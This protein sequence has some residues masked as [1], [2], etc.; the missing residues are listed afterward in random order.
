MVPV[1]A[2]LEILAIATAILGTAPLFPYL[3]IIPQVA[4]PAALALAII[5]EKMG[6]PNL[7][8]W[9]ATTLTG[10]FFLYYSLQISRDNVVDPS[11]NLLVI[12]LSIRLAGEKSPRNYLQIYALSIFALAASSLFSLSGSFLLYLLLILLSIAISLVLLTFFTIDNRLSLTRHG[13]WRVSSVAAFMPIASAPLILLFFVILPRPQFPLWNFLAPP[14][15]KATG[16]S[17]RVEPGAAASVAE[18]TTVALRVRGESLQRLALY[19]RGVV[20]NTPKGKAWVRTELDDSVAVPARP[21]GLVRQ[22]VYSELSSTPW[23][24]SLDTPLS[25]HGIRSLKLSDHVFRKTTHAS[26]RIRYETVSDIRGV[27]GTQRDIDRSFYLKLPEGLSPRIVSLGAD[28]SKK[29]RTA[30]QRL[31]LVERYFEAAGLRYSNQDMPVSDAP[32]DEFLFGKKAGNCEFFASSFALILRE[33]GVPSRLVGGYFGGN[34]NEL[35][36]YYL[37]TENMAH[38]WV[39]VFIEGTGWIRKDPSI[40]AANFLGEREAKKMGFLLKSRLLLDS[41]SYFWNQAVINY[42]LNKQISLFR[43]TGSALRD[44]SLPSGI[45]IV[46]PFFLAAGLV[47]AVFR[48]GMWSLGSREQ[49][50]VRKFIRKVARKYPQASIDSS[51]GLLE[52]SDQV[53]D[54]SVRRFAQIYYG[55]VYRDRRLSPQELDTLSRLSDGFSLESRATGTEDENRA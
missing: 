28:I 36:G 52:L 2:I 42:D 3:G 10:I 25:L 20:L 18:V 29:G 12:L 45:K 27:I 50:I 8:G 14:V 17:E 38:V 51:T 53:N 54:S 35:G 39:E 4:F 33:A 22:T 32:M 1:K 13:M 11:V 26:G 55:A 24:V 40:F 47:L 41:L 37:V 15:E 49:R 21:A 48:R 34:Y 46:L 7:K 43:S 19:W 44:F 31:S 23:L 16:L 6:F 5:S 9:R 30:S